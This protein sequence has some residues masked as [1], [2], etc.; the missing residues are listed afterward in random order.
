MTRTEWFTRSRA[1]VSRSSLR[2]SQTSD[3][4]ISRMTGWLRAWRTMLAARVGEAPLA[5]VDGEAEA[6]DQRARG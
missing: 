4:A 1:G 2:S 3:S 6:R 5:D